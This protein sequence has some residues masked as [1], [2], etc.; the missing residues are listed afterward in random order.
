MRQ[1]IILGGLGAAAAIALT[2]WQGR[3]R[4]TPSSTAAARTEAPIAAPA[5]AAPRAATPS[6]AGGET[7]PLPELVVEQLAEDVEDGD[8]HGHAGHAQEEILP[9]EEPAPSREAFG[10]DPRSE[11]AALAEVRATLEALLKDPDPAVKAQASTLLE[12][13]A[14][15]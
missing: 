1:L 6:R 7:R 13:I 4:A 15:Q 14:A 9:L 10:A 8:N 11:A 5:V 2:V 3:E 12:T